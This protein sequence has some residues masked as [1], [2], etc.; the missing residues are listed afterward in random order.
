MGRIG[1]RVIG[2]RAAQREST[3]PT[4]VVEAEA[5]AAEAR[6]AERVEQ[7]ARAEGAGADGD[8]RLVEAGGDRLRARRP[9]ERE[10]KERALVAPGAMDGEAVD[11]GLDVVPIDRLAARGRPSAR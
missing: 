8:A 10:G 4:R 5:R 3:S 2:S 6:H 7:R 11:G 1:Y 9:G